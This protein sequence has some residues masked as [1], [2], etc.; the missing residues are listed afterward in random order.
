MSNSGI[1]FNIIPVC[2]CVR[3]A[4]YVH[5][6][7]QNLLTTKETCLLFWS[8]SNWFSVTV[9]TVYSE[10]LLHVVLHW[11]PQ[12][13]IAL[14][15]YFELNSFEQ[16]WERMHTQTSR[17]VFRVMMKAFCLKL[18]YITVL[19]K[20]GPHI[21]IKMKMKRVKST[22]DFIVC[23]TVDKESWCYYIFHYLLYNL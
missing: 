16:F 18:M 22:S 15:A 1:S 20:K 7:A 23:W 4:D 8:F 6:C 9:L 14:K 11:R 3:C 2:Q 5:P 12:A 19:K 21:I 17:P 10:N 13:E